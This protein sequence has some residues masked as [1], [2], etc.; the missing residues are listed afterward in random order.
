MPLLFLPKNGRGLEREK[1]RDCCACCFAT[2]NENVLP[3]LLI[4]AAER[5]GGFG[6]F[7]L[8]ED[9]IFE[10]HAC[11]PAS[12]PWIGLSESIESEKEGGKKKQKS[13]AFNFDCY[14]LDWSVVRRQ[15][16]D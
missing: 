16:I 4:F 15:L 2:E 5:V 1:S 12:L 3:H 9:E 14:A 6:A 8:S 13:T 10:K 7:L 11:P